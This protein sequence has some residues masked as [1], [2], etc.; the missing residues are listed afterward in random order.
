VQY[1]PKVEYFEYFCTEMVERGFEYLESYLFT[2]LFFTSFS[3]MIKI[4]YLSAHIIKS[5]FK[6]QKDP[7]IVK[8]KNY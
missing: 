4:F 1:L 7:V 3:K 6:V 8:S 5:Y 2:S